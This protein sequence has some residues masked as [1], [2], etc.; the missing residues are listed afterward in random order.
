MAYYSCDVT[1]IIKRELFLKIKKDL[2]ISII[3]FI[4]DSD[5]MMSNY[6]SYK[7]LWNGISPSKS[8][9]DKFVQLRSYLSDCDLSDFRIIEYGIKDNDNVFHCISNNTGNY[10]DEDLVSIQ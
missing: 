10:I 5:R 4:D 8:S 3:D 6:N 1:L 7:I 2:S 9:W